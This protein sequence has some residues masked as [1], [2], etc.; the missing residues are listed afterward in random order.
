MHNMI[1]I[2]CHY[3]CRLKQ[4]PS[5]TT[6]KEEF[7][8][9]QIRLENCVPYVYSHNDFHIHN[10]VIDTHSEKLKVLGCGFLG[11]NPVGSD[12]VRLFA[13]GPIFQKLSKFL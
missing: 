13:L 4:L 7:V 5:K 10:V 6:L 2:H 8:K 1:I 9:L 11:R 3:N 12:I